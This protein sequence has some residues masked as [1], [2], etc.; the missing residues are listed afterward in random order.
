MPKRGKRPEL[1]RISPDMS[2]AKRHLDKA[3][4]NLNAM[5]LMYN[6]DF[7]DWTVIRGYYAMYHAVLAS[8]CSVGLR[9]FSHQCAISAF[10]KFFIVR[11]TTKKEYMD[12][13]RKAKELEKK[14]SDSLAKIRENRVIVQY[15]V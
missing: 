15:G 10:Q 6:D 7:F 3:R 9:A 1:R 14:Y 13:L 11:G 2:T 5:I 8:L 4:S 12:C